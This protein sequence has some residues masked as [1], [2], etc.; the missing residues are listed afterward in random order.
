MTAYELLCFLAKHPD[1]QVAIVE[2][3]E[4]PPSTSGKN[5]RYFSEVKSVKDN[6]FLDG[7]CPRCGRR[8]GNGGHG[9]KMQCQ[10]GWIGGLSPE[11][12]RTLDDFIRRHQ[13]RNGGGEI[14]HEG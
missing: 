2:G 14:T 12:Q 7:V 4:H 11:D 13:K 6:V 3:R 8:C 9:M 5:K 10:C 1:T